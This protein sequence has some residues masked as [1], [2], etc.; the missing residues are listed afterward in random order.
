M[1]SSSLFKIFDANVDRPVGISS[2]LFLFFRLRFL[3]LIVALLAVVAVLVVMQF[4]DD[5]QEIYAAAMWV[6]AGLILV[7]CCFM[8]YATYRNAAERNKR[9]KN[10]QCEEDERLWKEIADYYREQRKG[11]RS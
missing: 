1:N 5:Y 2:F 7:L 11:T 9:E 3:L 6:R 4:T 10:A 8:V